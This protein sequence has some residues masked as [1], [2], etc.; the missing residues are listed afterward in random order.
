MKRFLACFALTLCCL[1]IPQQSRASEISI[2][3]IGSLGQDN[4]D[5]SRFLYRVTVVGTYMWYASAANLERPV[6]CCGGCLTDLFDGL[7]H[8]H[9][10]RMYHFTNPPYGSS[11]GNNYLSWWYGS[12]DNGGSCYAYSTEMKESEWPIPYCPPY[13][14][15][16][17]VLQLAYD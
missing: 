13:S 14:E 6:T 15:C 7:G 5:C 2:L 4:T 17:G 12:K 11:C 3:T 9:C 1:A 10:V 16:L 8:L